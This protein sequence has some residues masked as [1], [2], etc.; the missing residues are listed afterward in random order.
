MGYGPITEEEF[1][2]ALTRLGERD[3]SKLVRAGGFDGDEAIW[4]AKWLR[5]EKP[6]PAPR[7]VPVP[8]PA[9]VVLLERDD[10]P[11][12]DE[13]PARRSSFLRAFRAA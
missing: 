8:A 2:Q 3:V 5:G 13:E 4:A 6:T 10:E 7:P 9:P 11:A 1:F 12:A